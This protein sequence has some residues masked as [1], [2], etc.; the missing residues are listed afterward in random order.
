MSS[1]PRIGWSFVLPML[2]NI[3]LSR[4]CLPEV[5]FDILCQLTVYLHLYIWMSICAQQMASVS[6][7]Y[8]CLFTDEMVS[9]VFSVAFRSVMMIHSYV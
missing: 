1:E 2:R 3:L 6:H 7:L 4:S 9:D 5:S 8:S